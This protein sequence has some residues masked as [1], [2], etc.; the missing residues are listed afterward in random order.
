MC[1]GVGQGVAVVVE[2]IEDC[3][4][5]RLSAGIGMEEEYL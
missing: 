4:E 1:I 3:G 5:F 2:R